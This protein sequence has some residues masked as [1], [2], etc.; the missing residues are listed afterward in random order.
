MKYKDS[1]LKILFKFSIL[2][3]VFIAGYWVNYGVKEYKWKRDQSIRFE[4]YN[5]DGFDSTT[6]GIHPKDTLYTKQNESF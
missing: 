3:L 5:R 4:K 2:M 1:L 6:R